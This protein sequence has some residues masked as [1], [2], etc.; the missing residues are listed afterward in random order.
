VASTAISLL[1]LALLGGLMWLVLR[2]LPAKPASQTIL[3]A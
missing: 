1:L 3:K 2:R